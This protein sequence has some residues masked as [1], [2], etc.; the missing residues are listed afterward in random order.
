MD[1]VK[2]QSILSFLW[3][4]LQGRFIWILTTTWQWAINR[5]FVTGFILYYV[6]SN[7]SDWSKSVATK[8]TLF[9]AS[10]K[11]LKKCGI[12][13]FVR[14]FHIRRC[15]YTYHTF[16]WCNLYVPSFQSQTF[17]CY[18]L[19]IRIWLQWKVCVCSSA[20]KLTYRVLASTHSSYI[21]LA[22]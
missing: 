20:K 3:F 22:S 7:S 5:Y 16:P 1:Q 12:C 14:A 19:H 8:P 15:I 13:T 18:H 6:A 2:V 10:A 4:R 17:S 21:S 11:N 9:I